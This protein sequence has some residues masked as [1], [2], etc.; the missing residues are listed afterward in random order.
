MSER[1][2]SWINLAK[3]AALLIVIF[4]HSTPRDVLTAVLTG[5]VLP[6]FFILYGVSHNSEKYRNR[7]KGYFFGRFRS[8]MIPYLVLTIGMVFLYWAVYPH[9]DVGLTPLDFVFWS[10]YGNGPPGRVTH[11]W[12]LRTMFFAIVLFSVVDRA[13]HDRSP[14][15]R[16]IILLG[17]PAIGLGLK[18]ALGIDLIPWSIDSILVAFSFMMIGQEIRRRR[19]MASWSVRPSLDLLLVIGA[20]ILCILLSWYNGY[21][22]IGES[23]YGRFLHIYI[24]TGVLGT[25]VVSV[26]SDYACTRATK[27]STMAATFNSYGQEVYEIHPLIIEANIQLLSGFSFWSFITI[28]PGAP[29]FILN[30]PLAIFLS[31]FLASKVISRSWFLEV[32]FRGWRR[33]RAV[34]EPSFSVPETNNTSQ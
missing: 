16:Y 2:I 25:Y 24:V 4:V 12:F 20:T 7:L 11:L 26:V 33:E 8:L 10:V 21:V 15:L 19:R 23:I 27:L 29:L 6:V 22:N 17:A 32:M 13:V 31:W 1:R 3:A 9:V 5:F 14:F 34:E 30:F 18:V 28:Y